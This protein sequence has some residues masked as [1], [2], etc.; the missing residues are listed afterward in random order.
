MY[1]ACIPKSSKHYHSDTHTAKIR[2]AT[3]IHIHIVHIFAYL[4]TY[5]NLTNT[6]N[7]YNS[8]ILLYKY[9]CKYQSCTEK[10]RYTHT[11][12]TLYYT[13]YTV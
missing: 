3:Y 2:V 7:N 12:Y 1:I 9:T 4:S 5:S 8:S 10:G 6:N 13:I 11:I